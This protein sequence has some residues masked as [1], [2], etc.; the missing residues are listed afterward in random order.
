MK[1]GRPHLEL[2]EQGAIW[3]TAKGTGKY[4]AGVHVRLRNGQRKQVTATGT[5]RAAARRRLQAKVDKMVTPADDGVQ[6][7][8][9]IDALAEHWL[10][11]KVRQGNSRTSAPLKPQTVWAY[12]DQITRIITPAIGSLRVHEATVSVIEHALAELESAGISTAQSRTVLTMMFALALRDGAVVTQ[13]MAHVTPPARE[14]REVE[15]LQVAE[16]R[17]LL[18]V[19]HPD[20]LR[21]PGRRRPN[22]DLLDVA[23]LGLATGARVS[24]LLAIQHRHVDLSGPAATVTISGTLVE[25][26]KGYVEALHRQETTKTGNDRTLVLPH[27]VL[28]MIETRLTPN[29]DPNTPLFAS[30]TGAWLWAANIRT[31]L[32]A[33]VE[34]DEV[35]RG[36]TPHTLR[37][38]VASAVA[39]EA[40][41]DAAR[42]QL[43]H[44]LLGNT[45]LA[46]YVAP[47]TQAPDLT[48]I[49]GRFFED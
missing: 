30:R 25:P 22:R 20:A 37:R 46:R 39:Y 36:T 9:T 26:R 47:R 1:G 34:N 4:V 35:L 2:A 11:R 31:R 13:P 21:I 38:T 44:S 15:I 3:V 43:G 48:H 23:T 8:W 27:A 16:A 33:A 24:E 17:R 6:P 29:T 19:I 18:A 42:M 14:P 49:L 32:R 12:Q 5:S 45:P 40:G 28:P 7:T 10:A 41:L